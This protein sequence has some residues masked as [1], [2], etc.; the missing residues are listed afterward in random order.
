MAKQS[1]LHF[2]AEGQRGHDGAHGRLEHDGEKAE[3]SQQ[4]LLGGI[5]A[6]GCGGE[7]AEAGAN[8][9]HAQDLVGGAGVEFAGDGEGGDVAEDVV[10]DDQKGHLDGVDLL[11]DG[12]GR[13]VDEAQQAIGE[14]GISFDEFAEFADVEGMF[15][16]DLQ[17]L[18]VEELVGRDLA[19]GQENGS[20]EVVAL[21]EG[22]AFGAGLLVFRCG[23]DFFRDQRDGVIFEVVEHGAA[24]RP[25]GGDEVDLD[26]VGDSDEGLEGWLPDEVVEG[27]AKPHGFEAATGGDEG[28]TGLDGFEDFEDGH[29][30]GKQAN[31]LAGK[32]IR[33]A[34]D[35]GGHAAGQAFQAEHDGVVDHG[36]GG[37]FAIAAEDGLRAAAKQQLVGVY[38]AVE[39]ENGLAREVTH[40]IGGFFRYASGC[41][42]GHGSLL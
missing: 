15:L 8:E 23:F 9:G 12:A 35:E 30:G 37:E 40:G 42:R 21:E 34:V 27:D 29:A 38:F 14:G 18:N 36:A 17:E 28:W 26:V 31:L 7:F 25:A 32:D 20:A 24:C 5:E 4:V 13:G 33:S 2:G 1:I 11:T 3:H 19:L 41:V 22:K 6:G 16:Q 10:A 39:I